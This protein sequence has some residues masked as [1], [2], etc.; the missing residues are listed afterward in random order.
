VGG[1]VSYAP[2]SNIESLLTNQKPHRAITG[3]E[4]MILLAGIHDDRAQS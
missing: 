1:E 2:V 4:P 3:G